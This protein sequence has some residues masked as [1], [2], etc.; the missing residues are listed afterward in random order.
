MKSMKYEYFDGWQR[1]DREPVGPLSMEEA[2]ARDSAG[3]NYCVAVKEDAGN[4][5]AFI[6]VSRNGFGV[7]FLDG[8][9]RVYLSYGFQDVGDGRLFLNHAHWADFSPGDEHKPSSVTNYHFNRTGSA[10]VVRASAPFDRAEAMD[11]DKDVEAN[12]DVRPAFGDYA[13]LLVKE[14]GTGAS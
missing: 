8:Q 12:W 10:T 9:G 11:T 13:H 2:K 7:S 1:S 3:Q 5:E 6:V 4:Y 14:R